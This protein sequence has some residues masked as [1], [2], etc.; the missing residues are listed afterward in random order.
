MGSPRSGGAGIATD[1]GAR[2]WRRGAAEKNR[3]HLLYTETGAQTWSFGGVPPGTSA[4][5]WV[6]IARWRPLRAGTLE[7]A[8]IRKKSKRKKVRKHQSEYQG[9]REE[10]SKQSYCWNFSVLR[11]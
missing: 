7:N 1:T 3:A 2:E 10:V 4:F 5:G 8:L 9:T 11:S 6:E